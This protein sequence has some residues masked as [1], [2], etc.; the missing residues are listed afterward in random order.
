AV[1]LGSAGTHRARRARRRAARRARPTLY[2]RGRGG[3]RGRGGEAPGRGARP[4]RAHHPPAVADRRRPA[5][6]DV[7]DDVDGFDDFGDGVIVTSV[8]PLTATFPFERDPLSYCF[9]RIET[10]SGLVGYGEACDSY[11]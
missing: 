8:T 9:V 1:D 3:A 10:D 4:G 11:G 6:A 2:D 5:C 7:G